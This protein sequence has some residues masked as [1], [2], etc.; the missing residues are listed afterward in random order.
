MLIND[1]FKENSFINSAVTGLS[2]GEIVRFTFLKNQYNVTKIK[3]AH[4]ALFVNN[5]MGLKIHFIGFQTTFY[6]ADT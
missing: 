4:L 2:D 6:H 1:V 5:A 3:K